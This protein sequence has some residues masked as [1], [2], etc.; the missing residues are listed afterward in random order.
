MPIEWKKLGR[1]VERFLS[2]IVLYVAFPLVPLLLELIIDQ[3][4]R[5]ST[6]EITLVV[7]AVSIG[8][9]SKSFFVLA[10]AIFVSILN[11]VFYGVSIV[12]PGRTF[13]AFTVP[14]LYICIAVAV[15]ERTIRHVVNRVPVFNFS[16]E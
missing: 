9:D 14:S 13:L 3:K 6:L 1:G 15:I 11:S 12:D 4:V 16:R 2:G 7:F 5:E 8:S 10:L